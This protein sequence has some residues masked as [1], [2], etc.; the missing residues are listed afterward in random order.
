MLASH[1]ANIQICSEFWS[2]PDFVHKI[3]REVP[4]PQLVLEGLILFCSYQQSKSKAVP[5]LPCLD[6][7]SGPPALCCCCPL[8][9][10]WQA[11]QCPPK[12]RVQPCQSW[13]SVLPVGCPF[14]H[15][16]SL[17]WDLSN[18]LKTENEHILHP[19]CFRGGLCSCIFFTPCLSTSSKGR[20]QSGCVTLQQGGR[21]IQPSGEVAKLLSFCF[22]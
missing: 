22:D 17:E 14:L 5:E 21:T 6:Q 8:W 18:V 3:N 15:F 2:C 4:Q 10:C 16:A 11:A 1:Y 13:H 7:P 12:L 20:C 19:Y 9:F